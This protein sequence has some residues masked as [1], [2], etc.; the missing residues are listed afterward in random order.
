M[1]NLLV[2]FFISFSFL[3]SVK[4]QST[5]NNLDFEDSTFNNWLIT[6]G[7]VHVIGSPPAHPFVL[8]DTGVKDSLIY[9]RASHLINDS[10]KFDLDVPVIPVLCPFTNSHSVRLGNYRA[11]GQA[12]RMITI[13]NVTVA[14]SLL[15]FYYAYVG[16]DPSHPLNEDPYFFFEILDS[17]GGS[18]T[19]ID[20]IFVK[21]GS[22]SLTATGF[23]MSWKYKN[24]SIKQF[25]LSAYAGQKIMIRLTNGDCGYGGHEGR[26]YFDFSMN[27]KVTANSIVLCDT[28]SVLFAGN[29]ITTSGFY[30]DTTWV[31]GVVDSVSVLGVEVLNQD[32]ILP[33][34]SSINL[35]LCQGDTLNATCSVSDFGNDSTVY[36]WF[37]NG[38]SS[39]SYDSVF[40]K[41]MNVSGTFSIFCKMHNFSSI[42]EKVEFSD[43][44][45]VK[46]YS[47]PSVNL[48]ILGADLKAT[49][50]GGVKPYIYKWYIWNSILTSA[51]DSIYTPIY[52]GDHFIV[53]VDSNGCPATDSVTGYRV[54][55]EE[56]ISINKLNF[57]PNPTKD[58]IYLQLNP[59][60]KGIL[61]IYDV[62]GKIV[63]QISVNKVN[64]RIDVKKL[65]KGIYYLSLEL[66]NGEN[67]VGKVVLE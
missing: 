34:L 17:S 46:V 53:I 62:N 21:A 12:E 24:W 5:I 19:L 63:K 37:V 18:L 23:M 33:S 26:S 42:C 56:M 20:S 48:S 55:L 65:S 58:I 67:I 13:I 29:Y 43:T 22:P 27:K 66:E 38:V 2:L 7:T 16:F 14:D 60:E 30:Y 47:N 57:Y 8:L 45:S 9:N 15:D 32:S 6:T 54:G 11:G 40:K 35:N 10:I 51:T 64:N 39:R 41:Q 61:K 36:E 1:K 3:T 59:T 50:T 4:S 25:N 49:A 28:D 44:I 52:N 31:G